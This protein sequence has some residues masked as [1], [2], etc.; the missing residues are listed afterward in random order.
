VLRIPRGEQGLI[1]F[2]SPAIPDGTRVLICYATHNFGLVEN[3]IRLAD[4]VAAAFS[5]R[6]YT[7]TRSTFAP[8]PEPEQA[9]LTIVTR[10]DDA[11]LEQIVKQ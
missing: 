8:T 5:G 2:R 9:A 7:S 11:T 1:A 6:G 10:G 3:K 4:A